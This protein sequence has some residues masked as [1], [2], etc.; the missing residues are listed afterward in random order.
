MWDSHIMMANFCSDEVID[1]PPLRCG[2]EGKQGS[3]EGFSEGLPSFLFEV[4]TVVCQRVLPYQCRRASIFEG[5]D[6]PVVQLSTVM[7]VRSTIV[8]VRSPDVPPGLKI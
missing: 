3:L 7:T 6:F 4:E 2:L 1:S 5:F 8:R